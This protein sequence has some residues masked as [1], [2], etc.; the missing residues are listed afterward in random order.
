MDNEQTLETKYNI[1]EA[2]FQITNLY[3][4]SVVASTSSEKDLQ[5]YWDAS[6][7]ERSRRL[8]LLT[9]IG[10]A[11]SDLNS[12][13]LSQIN[14]ERT[15]WFSTKHHSHL[16]KNL[17]ETS[18][19][20]ST[21]SH[22]GF[23]VCENII[24]KSKKIR[25]YPKKNRKL[26]NYLGLSRYWYNQTIEYLRQPKTTANFFEIR[27]LLKTKTQPSWAFECPSRIIDHSIKEACKAV[28]NA[29][30]K[31]LQT[32]KFQEVKFKTK[33][34]Y[35]QG[36]GFDK[37][38]LN[39]NF[40]FGKKEDRIYFKSTEVF[41]VEQEGTKII[42]ENGRW[43]II[44]PG[45]ATI[46]KPEN[47][48]FGIVALDPGV[49]TFI[50][51]YSQEFHGKIGEGDFNRIFRLCLNLDKMISKSSKCKAK[52]RRSIKRA[53]Q[54][55]RWKIKDLINDLHKKTANFLVKHFD[56]ILIPTFETQEMVSKLRS[57]TARSMLN[58][59]YY[60]FKQFLKHKA[61]EYSCLVI[62]VSEAWTS[63]TCSYCGKVY[64]KNSKKVMKCDCGAIV[65]RDLNGARGIYLRALRA[66][67][68]QL[69]QYGWFE[70]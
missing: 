16:K 5:P 3:K 39:K 15:S 58:F 57:K 30:L 45:R 28:S 62:E 65:D 7:L 48:R 21:F 37:Q 55:L 50:T 17:L 68:F 40:V 43:Y 66:S 10:F 27:K 26:N 54:K 20:L 60:R 36:F 2:D 12:L 4:T 53:C 52:Q 25:I 8:L 18:S 34:S 46:K 14:L 61:R 6:C 42:K 64:P 44:V 63:R 23:T 41:D 24:S 59:A 9:E 38:S 35:S 70:C 29:K 1:C 47:Q 49:R 31:F 67:S 69:N 51:Y 13:S 33:K 11:G 32:K 22:P 19:Q 56:V